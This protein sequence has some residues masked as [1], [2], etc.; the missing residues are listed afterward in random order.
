MMQVLAAGIAAVGA[1][2]RR[3]TA[4]PHRRP[5]SASIMPLSMRP[6]FPASA[7]LLLSRLLYPLRWPH[8][9]EREF[10][11]WI[12]PYTRCCRRAGLRGHRGGW[13]ADIPRA[14]RDKERVA[15]THRALAKKLGVDLDDG[16]ACLQRGAASGP[17][18]C[19]GGAG[20][21]LPKAAPGRPGMAWRPALRRPVDEP[22]AVAH[23]GRFSRPHPRGLRPFSATTAFRSAEFRGMDSLAGRGIAADQLRRRVAYRRGGPACHLVPARKCGEALLLSA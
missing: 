1:P 7:V 2:L 6:P 17:D 12:E 10:I 8:L 13:S 11:A 3:G 19:K 20:T 21:L 23:R 14:A 16:H 5:G 9:P 15:A 22:A 4:C 18:R